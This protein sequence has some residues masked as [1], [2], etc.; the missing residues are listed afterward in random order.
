MWRLVSP[1]SD[2]VAGRSL[3]FTERQPGCRTAQG[4]NFAGRQEHAVTLARLV[5]AAGDSGPPRSSADYWSR[6]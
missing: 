3:L 5:P 6:P 4:H 1:A 2:A